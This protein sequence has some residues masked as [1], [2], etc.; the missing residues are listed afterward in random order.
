MW[1][2]SRGKHRL[3]LFK[4]YWNVVLLCGHWAEAAS[5]SKLLY[6]LDT[7]KMCCELCE[8]IFYIKH[9][10]MYPVYS[11]C[12][13]ISCVKQILPALVKSY[14]NE[15]LKGYHCAWSTV[16][17]FVYQQKLPGPV[18]DGVVAFHFIIHDDLST[19]LVVYSISKYGIKGKHPLVGWCESGDHLL[20]SGV[21]ILHLRRRILQPDVSKWSPSSHHPTLGVFIYFDWC[22][23]H[24]FHIEFPSFICTA[25]NN[26]TLFL[27]YFAC[28]VGRALFATYLVYS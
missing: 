8:Y 5:S 19:S 14:V 3:M 17:R 1:N 16:K 13:L 25:F 4:I 9:D 18:C 21:G 7:I 26:I 20:T 6:V 23:I 2:A 22:D 11:V 10:V 24:A 15:G 12:L 27:K 28:P